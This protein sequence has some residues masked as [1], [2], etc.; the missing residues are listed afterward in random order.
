MR[1]AAAASSSSCQWPRFTMAARQANPDAAA[2]AP[3]LSCDTVYFTVVDG[4]GNC[5]SFIN[6]NYKE[7]GSGERADHTTRTLPT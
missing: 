3:P 4:Q 2:G 6:S 7:F 1:C 5:A